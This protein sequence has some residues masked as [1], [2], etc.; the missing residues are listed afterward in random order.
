MDESESLQPAVLLQV[1]EAGDVDLE[2]RL[3]L[4]LGTAPVV[5]ILVR[6]LPCL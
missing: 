4:V 5:P 1:D 3:V 2:R 6:A